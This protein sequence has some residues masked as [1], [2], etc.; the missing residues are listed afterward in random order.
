MLLQIGAGLG[1][2]VVVLY[3]LKLRR[4]PVAVPFG[5]LWQRILGDKE[6]TT[7]FSQLKRLLSLLLQLLL[8]AL[9][10]LAIGDPR[11]AVSGSEGRHVV[12]LL[13][14]SASMQAI[15]VDDET[16]RSAAE[17]AGEA[18]AKSR[19]GAAKRRLRE[20]LRGLSG[21]D[22]MLIAQMDAAVTPL[23]T[24]T[25]NVEEL[26]Q[27]LDQVRPSDA[28]ADFAKALRFAV[29]SLRG[30]SRPE[31]LVVSDGA[32]VTAG[33]ELGG[34][35]LGEAKLSF[36]GL[37]RSA[38]NLAITGFA[39]RRYPLDK[40]RYEVLLEAT[41]TS[42]EDLEAQIEL[43]GDGA[44]TDIV[45]L[46]LAAGETLS[47]F[48]PNLSGASKTLEAQIK[49]RGGE[50]DDLPA[51]DRAYALLPERRRARVQVVTEGN[52]YLEAALLLDEY[53]DVV[54]V[55]PDEYPGPGRYDVTIFD[56]VAPPVAD[57]SGHVLY[58]NPAGDELPFEVGKRI[59]SDARYTVGFDEVDD[60][61][62]LLR[63]LSLGDV[64]VATAHV[65][66]GE[67]QDEVVGR[68]FKGPLL[69]HGRRQGRKFVA[70][71]F[72]IRDSDLPLRIAWPLLLLNTVNFFIEEDTSYI[73]SFQ[74]GR[75]WQI[76]APS[77]VDVAT[78]VLP[79]KEQRVVSVKDG[80]AVYL[81]QHAGF[82]ELRAGEGAVGETTTFAANMI[83]RD[84]SSIAPQ[85]KLEVAE[86]EAGTIAGFVAGVRRELWI[87]ILAVV[88]LLTALEWLTYHRRVTV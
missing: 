3:V 42:D 35:D 60:K 8:L 26:R 5:P 6:A 11:T 88:L 15:D 64:N 2:V 78:L 58:L 45:R 44:L 87:Y 41:N 43:F 20:L 54:T 28:A 32:L 75:V 24:M 53:L 25:G 68:S 16:E 46:R 1:A 85:A 29:D 69:I 77:D 9:L 83:D 37:G 67:E 27:A 49:L 74:T 52:M 65:L 50:P 51:D 33:D 55:A 66:A 30:L 38:K 70:L 36:I 62:P 19:L 81:G 82:Y 79:S 34:V 18:P 80:R 39:V 23:S 12:V 31:V 63:H 84:E 72:D 13:D 61:S 10:L 21:Q 40:S 14:A 22:R 56:D 17:P 57:G 71:G 59:E 76:P 73:S 86:R 4:R 48:Y 7:L 47:R